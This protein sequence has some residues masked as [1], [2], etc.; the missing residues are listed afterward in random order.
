MHLL[1]ALGALTTAT[2]LVVACS[3]TP[4]HDAFATD[5]DASIDGPSKDARDEALTD[6][7]PT[8]GP[9]CVDDKQ[10]DDKIACTT[11]KCDATIKRCRYTG[12]ATLCDDAVYCNGQ[13]TCLAGLG[14]KPGAPVTCSDNDPCTIGLCDEP[15]RACTTTQ[16]D[17][18]GDGDPDDHCVKKRDCNDADPTVSS[19]ASEICANGKDDNCDGKIDEQGCVTAKGDAC[20]SPLAFTMGTTTLSTVGATFSFLT[21]CN[22]PSPTSAHDVVGTFTVPAGANR[23]V[24]VTAS[25]GGSY[26]A[27]AVMGTCGDTT[28]EKSCDFSTTLARTRTRNLAPG[29]YTIWVATQYDATVTLKIA[30]FDATTAPTNETCTSPLAVSLDT[31]FDVSLVGATLDLPS[32]CPASSGE[33]TY[34]FTLASAKDI[35]I[36][37][38]T[39]IGL[40]DPVL[41]LRT[42][43]CTTTTDEI[44]CRKNASLPLFA[45]N[46]P[47]GNYVLSVAASDPIDA[48]VVIQAAAPTA[49][50]PD[51]SCSTAPSI[52]INK[53]TSLSLSDR[54]DVIKDDCFPGNPNGAYAF[55]V[56]QASDV[57]LVARYSQNEIG[58]VS[59][60]D[61]TCS[62]A[63]RLGCSLSSTPVRT[64]ARNV[65]PGSY[66]AVLTDSL[67]LTA[68]ITPLV[69]PF[70]A[71]TAISGADDCS[72]AFTI[73]SGG[74]LF[75]GDTT[76][77][78]AQY[79]HGC[80]VPTVPAGGAADQ[81]GKLVLTQKQR[82]VLELSATGYTP[83]LEIQKGA[84]CPAQLI[85]GAC[86][87]GF[88][89]NKS[90]LD[91]DLDAGTYYVFI[92]G[93][94]LGKGAWTLNAHVVDP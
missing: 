28:T 5:L 27:V 23:D 8:I 67:G 6:A 30:L 15:T 19:L 17:S 68:T 76:F 21:K 89:S 3:T 69:R 49:E 81:V 4:R 45:R 36:F 61:S 64:F 42:P 83:I 37:A 25:S 59:L 18:D 22:M 75:T 84:T 62:V 34:S 54:A 24:E 26:I 60:V 13:E 74:G 55:T 11:D 12:D 33:L 43:S 47:A 66:R 31:A 57:L 63:T 46:L 7:D 14:C 39:T 40:V 29:T 58:A 70:A 93:Y 44:R 1:R 79:D 91:L 2:A 48:T 35:H 50:P 53:T 92:D 82:V 38:S 94:N 90:F 20:T 16:R 72:T 32:A 86:H 73:P 52:P 85:K 88:Q 9:P 80:D 10:C 65:Q 41:S 78:N 87:V 71:S 51:Q 77:S 56:S